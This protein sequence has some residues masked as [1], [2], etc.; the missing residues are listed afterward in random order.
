MSHENLHF[1]VPSLFAEL[2][3]C[4]KLNAIVNIPTSDNEAMWLQ[5]LRRDYGVTPEWIKR[6][7]SEGTSFRKLCIAYCRSRVS[8]AGNVS[9]KIEDK[10]VRKSESLKR[11]AKVHGVAPF[12]VA[13]LWNTS[14]VGQRTVCAKL[15]EEED[16]YF[17]KV[18]EIRRC[19]NIQIEGA[20]RVPVAGFYRVTWRVKLA[21]D[22]EDVGPLSF[23]SKVV[24]R[25]SG[26]D[27]LSEKERTELDRKEL[28]WDESELAMPRTFI[29][30]SYTYY[31]WSPTNPVPAQPAN[32]AVVPVHPNDRPFGAPE[33]QANDAE[34]EGFGFQV[35]QQ[36]F[37]LRNRLGDQNQPPPNLPPAPAAPA[38]APA[39]AGP[40]SATQIAPFPVNE[41]FSILTG[42]IEVK[43]PYDAVCFAITN[44]SMGYKY[45]FF[46]D[47]ATLTPV[48]KRE[49]DN[50]DQ[51][52]TGPMLMD[53]HQ[54][55]DTLCSSMSH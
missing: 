52:V 9:R 4:Q 44:F 12:Y 2:Q 46:F 43:N 33:Q 42:F 6:F 24:E 54:Y 28:A 36:L 55:W 16:S 53:D 35:Q 32:A 37:L 17:S 51:F 22:Y 41:W 34:P 11:W 20:V 31:V 19:W 38:P 13:Q 25:Y 1:F 50:R 27:L 15:T 29:D 8:C 7:A 40:V 48:T 30:G 26:S 18:L 23:L 45:G 49:F 10:H 5:V 21:P 47:H 39:P 3:V 14:T